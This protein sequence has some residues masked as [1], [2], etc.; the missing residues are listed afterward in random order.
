[1]YPKILQKCD[2][3]LVKT[4][5]GYANRKWFR[6]PLTKKVK[7]DKETYL[8]LWED[9]KSKNFPEID[10]IEKTFGYAISPEFLHQL[11]LHTQVVIKKS[12]I[13]YQHG[14]LL[15][16]ILSKLISETDADSFNIVETGTAM[17]FSSLCMAKALQDKN[18][19]GK[20]LT[21][22]VL[23]HQKKI[24][25]NCIDD[26]EGKKTRVELLMNYTDLC[27]R[28]IIFHQ[29]NTVTE[30]SKVYM[31]RIHF[32]FL[33]GGHDYH[34][35]KA[36]LKHIMPCQLP[37]DVILFDD[38]SPPKFPGLAKAVDEMCA[39]FQYTKELIRADKE[40]S[41]LLARKK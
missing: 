34:H 17:G 13:N 39:D 14:R 35:L 9:A 31:T 18:A 5:Y 26:L 8:R 16:A 38:Y 23:P 3:F 41:Y 37:G 30:M 21:F 7:A 6:N 40:R 24:Y 28:Y 4:V 29:G 12:S 1:M 25:W 11:A 20:I 32:A 19:N 33:D 36:E 10:T 22:D 2:A 27:I 15:Y